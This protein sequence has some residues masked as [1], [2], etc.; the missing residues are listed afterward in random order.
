MPIAPTFHWAWIDSPLGVAGVIAQEGGCVRRV[1]LPCATP[2]ESRGCMACA[3]RGLLSPAGAAGRPEEKPFDPES[4]ADLA[5]TARENGPWA[6]TAKQ[7][8]AEYLEGRRRAF[9]VPFALEGVAAFSRQ[10]LLAAAQIP[11]GQTR[12]YWW[13]AVRAGNPRAVRAVGQAMA[14]NPVP[15][16][17]PCHRVVRSDGSLGGFGGGG[18][19]QKRALLQ[20]EARVAAARAGS[21]QLSFA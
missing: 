13:V 11:Y 7:Q 20:L 12:S 19:E 15:L 21:K 3:L 4:I 14:N 5:S 9:D 16:I 1:I 17:V 10:A 2:E 18:P 8:I 6:L